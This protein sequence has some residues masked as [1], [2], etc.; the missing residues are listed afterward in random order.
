MGIAPA[1]VLAA[2]VGGAVSGI[3]QSTGHITMLA[4][5]GQEAGD[6]AVASA[7][8]IDNLGGNDPLAVNHS[9]FREDSALSTPGNA[10]DLDT[11]AVAELL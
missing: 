3:S 1:A 11:Q 7:H 6:K 10:Y 4:A 9:V 8:G 2:G 5:V